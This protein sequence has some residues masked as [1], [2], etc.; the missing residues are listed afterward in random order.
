MGRMVNSVLCYI[1]RDGQ[2][3]MLYRNVKRADP[4]KGK[5]IGLG[6]KLENGETPELMIY[7]K[8]GRRPDLACGD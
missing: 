8:T 2:Y 1:E 6:G 3:L 4:N 7:K 5:W